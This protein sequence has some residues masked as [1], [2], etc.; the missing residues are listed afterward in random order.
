MQLDK[1]KKNNL[2]DFIQIILIVNRW[3][4]VHENRSTH[5]NM[6]CLNGLVWE[7]SFSINELIFKSF[8]TKINFSSDLVAETAS[9]LKAPDY[10]KPEFIQLFVRSHVRFYFDA[11]KR[12]TLLSNLI[13]CRFINLLAWWLNF[14]SVLFQSKSFRINWMHVSVF[15]DERT[16]VVTHQRQF[17][18]ICPDGWLNTSIYWLQTFINASRW[19]H[20]TLQWWHDK[21]RKRKKLSSATNCLYMSI[22][23]NQHRNR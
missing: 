23:L 21:N 20:K 18:F 17:R 5:Q 8:T 10:R 13:E 14:V 2:T 11:F 9:V 22:N 12:N 16:P 6:I 19:C 7:I 15:I 4:N 1:W 3:F